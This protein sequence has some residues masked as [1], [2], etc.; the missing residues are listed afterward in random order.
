LYRQANRTLGPKT[1]PGVF[2]FRGLRMI[3]LS[4]DSAGLTRLEKSLLAVA[5][6]QIPYAAARALNDCAR[7]ARDGINSRMGETFDRPTPFTT[8][9]VVAP[10]ELA[11]ETSRLE[12]TVTVRPV[13]QKYL[14]HEE[15][16]GTRD[17]AEN[18]RRPG[19]TAIVL[20]GRGLLLNQFGN[21]PAG[22][23]KS[24]NSQIKAQARSGKKQAAAA[25]RARAGATKP[26]PATQAGTIAYLPSSARGNK[27]QIGGFFRRTDGHGLTRLTGFESATHYQPRF[28]Y[29]DRV[30]TIARATW[31]DAFRR[32][33]VEA[34]R[35]AR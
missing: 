29:R 14:L 11:A 16:G 9:A 13:Q 10:R 26:P 30:E 23:L 20:P 33:L 8:R 6:R 34:A 5:G 4:I 21:I 31:P 12:A 27:A 22:T 7:A 2:R 25:K 1:E 19:A 17:P 18:T 32:R 24:L 15:I 35:S 28:H 3:E